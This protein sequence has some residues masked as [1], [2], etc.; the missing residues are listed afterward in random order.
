MF[1]LDHPSLITSQWLNNFGFLLVFIYFEWCKTS[2]ECYYSKFYIICFNSKS[3]GV[4]TLLLK[5]WE[6]DTHTPEMGT[7]EP[8]RTPKISEFDCRGQNTSHWGFLYTIGKRSKCRCQKWARMSHLDI[9]S[10]SYDE[11]KSQESNWQFNSRP[12][13][14]ENQLDPSACKWSATHR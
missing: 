4:I 3:K 13:K 5:E 7:W 6:D 8:T 11:K 12:L 10:T 2:W 14:V 9:C 1:K